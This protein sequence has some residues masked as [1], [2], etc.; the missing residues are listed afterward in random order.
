MYG[1]LYRL[2][3]GMERLSSS[4]EGHQFSEGGAQ[5]ITNHIPTH[6][7]FFGCRDDHI[8]AQRQAVEGTWNFHRSTTLVFDTRQNDQQ[9]NIA[10]GSRL[11]ARPGTEQDDAQRDRTG[12]R[13][14]GQ[15]WAGILVG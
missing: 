5:H 4:D 6:G 2:Y 1:I 3:R 11:T 10:V 12:A 15:L 14:A 8:F 9:V 7:D 13:Y